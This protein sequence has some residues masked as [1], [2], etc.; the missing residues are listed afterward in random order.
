MFTGENVMQTDNQQERLDTKWIAGF[1]DGEGCFHV[2]INRQQKMTLGWQ[3]LPE[4]RVVQHQRDEQI[5]HRI[6]AM[7]GFGNVVVNHGDRKEFRVRGLNNLNKIVK[8]FKEHELQTKKRNDFEKLALI[9][10][11]MNK[12]EHLSIT[13]LKYIARIASTMNK[14]V[15]SRIL[16]DCTSDNNMVEDTVR[17]LQ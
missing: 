14:S 16:R 13:G 17:P 15:T 5:L 9:I 6:R 11:M 8:F 2:A 4:F 3:V 12:G 1:V 10:S 7:F